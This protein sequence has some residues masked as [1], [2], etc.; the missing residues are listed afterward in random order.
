MQNHES[1]FSFP[2]RPAVTDRCKDL[3]RCLLQ[4][5]ERRL[6]SHRYRINDQSVPVGHTSDGALAPSSYPYVFPDDAEDIKC[7]R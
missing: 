2:V 4:E 3:M 6:S 7:H 1:T 5:P